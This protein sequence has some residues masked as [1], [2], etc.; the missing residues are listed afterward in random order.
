MSAFSAPFV[1]GHWAR[2]S[3]LSTQ[4]ID[5]LKLETAL[6]AYYAA[7]GVLTGTTVVF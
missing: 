4:K 7:K 6:E 1:V 2:H 3:L 5:K